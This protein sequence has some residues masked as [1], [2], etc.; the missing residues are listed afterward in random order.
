MAPISDWFTAILGNAMESCSQ[1]TYSLC[2]RTNYYY[3][4]YSSYSLTTSDQNQPM[5]LENNY[6]YVNKSMSANYMNF[7]LKANT[8]SGRSPAYKNLE[9]S[10]TC[11]ETIGINPNTLASKVTSTTTIVLVYDSTAESTY[12]ALTISDGYDFLG[13][14]EGASS[15]PLCP[16][17]SLKIWY[18]NQDNTYSLATSTQH[19]YLN[20]EN[21]L[22]VNIKSGLNNNSILIVGYATVGINGYENP[23]TTTGFISLILTED[24]CAKFEF[25]TKNTNAVAKNNEMQYQLKQDE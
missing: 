20:S 10:L 25:E 12:K 19:Y 1:I 15:D 5:W 7:T 9:L 13:A 6:L 4:E 8:P 23:G 24:Y 16:V 18:L 2:T 14:F 21:Q 3:C 22:Q 17:D 11:D